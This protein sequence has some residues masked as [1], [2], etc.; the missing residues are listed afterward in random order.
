MRLDAAGWRV[1]GVRIFTTF[2]SEFVKILDVE[3]VAEVFGALL[4]DSDEAGTIIAYGELFGWTAEP[5]TRNRYGRAYKEGFHGVYET[6]GDFARQHVCE[7]Q[8]EH[9]PDYVVVDWEKTYN[10][11]S[12]GFSDF[13]YDNRFYV[14]FG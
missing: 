11:I 7:D 9:I 8:D 2:S 14:F 13:E 3:T 10:E 1:T 12:D 4:E 6:L 5:F